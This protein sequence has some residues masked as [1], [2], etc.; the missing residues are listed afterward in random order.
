MELTGY[1]IYKLFIMSQHII[2]GV[3]YKP[4]KLML[5]SNIDS[6][7]PILLKTDSPTINSQ[8]TKKPSTKK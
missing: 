1:T 8:P 5:V 6:A 2:T 4:Y 7:I 3:N